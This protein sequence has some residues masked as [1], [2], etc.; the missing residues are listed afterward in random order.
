MEFVDSIKEDIQ[1][2][3]QTGK[4][5]CILHPIILIRCTNAR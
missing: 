2:L 4:I 1:W 5:I 3:G